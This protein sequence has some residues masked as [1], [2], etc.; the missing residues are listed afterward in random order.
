[1]WLPPL[2]ATAETMGLVAEG[3]AAGAALDRELGR[4]AKMLLSFHDSE[5]ANEKIVT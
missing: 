1:M 4:G 3:Y 5:G 2:E